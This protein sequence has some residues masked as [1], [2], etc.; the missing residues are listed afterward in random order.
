MILI[1]ILKFRNDIDYNVSLP[2]LHSMSGQSYISICL[3]WFM[4]GQ[5]LSGKSFL[6]LL[7]KILQLNRKI[8]ENVCLLQ[9]V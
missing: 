5:I 2:V 7:F 8:L 9:S 6:Y 4:D 3:V 1:R